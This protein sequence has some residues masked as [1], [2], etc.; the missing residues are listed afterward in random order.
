MSAAFKAFLNS[1]VGPKTT[2]FWGPVSNWGIILASVA[3]T[4]KPP[5][6]IS[7]NMTGVLCVYSALFVR[8]A[9]MVRP[10]NYFLMATHSCN[11]VVQLYQLSRWARAQKFMEKKE[12]GGPTIKTDP[13]P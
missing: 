9:W 12:L 3:D 8:F 7:G 5:E 2:H 6:M 11:E 10:Q 4:Q 13:K 1:P